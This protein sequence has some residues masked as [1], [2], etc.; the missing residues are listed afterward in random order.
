L[1]PLGRP[2]KDTGLS[3]ERILLR[4]GGFVPLRIDPTLPFEP[5]TTT[6]AFWKR[7]RHSSYE[8]GRKTLPGLFRLDYFAVDM[9]AFL[10]ALALEGWGLFNLFLVGQIEP[11]YVAVLFLLDIVLAICAHLP[12]GGIQWRENWLVYEADK[13]D[14]DRLRAQIRH[15]KWISRFFA[16]LIFALAA[17]KIILFLA[18]QQV[19]DS[20]TAGI[21]VSYA[22]VAT[23]HVVATG[24]F[25]FALAGDLSLKFDRFRFRRSSKET[26]DLKILG[27]RTFPF[28]HKGALTPARANRHELKRIK[29]ERNR[30]VLRTWGLLMDN[31]V[32]AFCLAQPD[33][34]AAV[35]VAEESV[36]AQMRIM[37]QEPTAVTAET[38]GSDKP[39]GS[40]DQRETEYRSNVTDFPEKAI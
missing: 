15:R 37:E 32:V 26:P 10:S 14:R 40:Q 2:Q 1:R 34:Q 11:K 17:F 19:F 21:T 4:G 12:V 24:S 18:L 16:L 25:L 23:I 3:L 22:V 30:Y 6:K 20:V 33:D 36:E 38:Y 29:G 28:E 35:K 39:G 7:V 31:E 8:V 27:F 5:S 13:T 9:F